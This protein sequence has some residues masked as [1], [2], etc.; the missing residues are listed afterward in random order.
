MKSSVDH[1]QSLESFL[2]QARLLFDGA[3]SPTE[4]SAL[5]Y[6]LVERCGAENLSPVP[7]FAVKDRRITCLEIDLALKSLA[8]QGL[9]TKSDQV[10]LSPQGEALTHDG[11]IVFQKRLRKL[12][13]TDFQSVSHCA[14]LRDD[15]VP[16]AL[17]LCRM[18]QT[19]VVFNEET[20]ALILSHLPTCPLS[21]FQA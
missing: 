15:I 6:F 7:V 4:F 2:L 12:W 21:S 20:Q 16:A 19:L 3:I 11:N 1:R 17:A 14:R 13:Q 9:L 5:L 18:K 8:N 10:E